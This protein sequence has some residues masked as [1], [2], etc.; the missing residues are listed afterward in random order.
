[1]CLCF[2]LGERARVESWCL[3]DFA[4]ARVE[5]ECLVD[6][7]MAKAEREREPRPSKLGQIWYH[8]CTPETAGMMLLEQ[9]RKRRNSQP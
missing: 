8:A 4:K 7:Q 6:F 9:T 2:Y 5:S 3:V 1:M